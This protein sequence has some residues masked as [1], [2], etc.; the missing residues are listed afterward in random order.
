MKLNGPGLSTFDLLYAFY[1]NGLKKS[2]N[3]ANQS[4]FWDI[5]GKAEEYIGKFVTWDIYN[6]LAEKVNMKDSLL[7]SILLGRLSIE[8]GGISANED[9]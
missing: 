7:F 4:K 5:F 9:F 6:P 1:Y 3:K 2:T 8:F